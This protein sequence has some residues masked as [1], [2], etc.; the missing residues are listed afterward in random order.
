[1]KKKS[2][3]ILLT[4]LMLVILVITYNFLKPQEVKDLKNST[5]KINLRKP[6][7]EIKDNILKITPLGTS[8]EDVLKVIETNKKWKIDWIRDKYPSNF[9]NLNADTIIGNKSAKAYIGHYYNP[10][11]TDVE[12]YWGFDEEDKLIEI[13]IRKTKDSL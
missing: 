2:I 3:Y 13:G 4:F 12:I 8:M 9:T 11:L 7:E 5:V 6:E 10:F 1:M